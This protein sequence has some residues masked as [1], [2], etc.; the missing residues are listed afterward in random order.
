MICR[1]SLKKCIE[2]LIFQFN[3]AGHKMLSIVACPYGKY[4]TVYSEDQIQIYNTK[5]KS[6]DMRLLFRGTEREL[7]QF[8]KIVPPTLFDEVN[9]DESTSDHNGG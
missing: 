6:N 8:A 7:A 1:G 3:H 9:A 5:I 2:C 4:Y